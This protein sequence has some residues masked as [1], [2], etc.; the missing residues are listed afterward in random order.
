MIKRILPIALAGAALIG[1]I[2]CKNN[3]DMKHVNGID[4]KIIHDAPGK[5]AQIGDVVE[6]NIKVMADTMTIADSRKEAGK[7]VPMQV[8]AP[9]F[10][11][12]Y[13]AVFPMLS[14]GD[15]ALVEVSCDTLIKALQKQQAQLPPFIKRGKKI[16]FIISI[17]SVKSMDEFK[18]DMEAKKAGLV[19]Q[20]DKTLQDYFA[21]HNI[22]AQKTAS[23]L[24]YTIDKEGTGDQIVKGRSVTMNYTGKLLN[25]T[26]FDSNTEPVPGRPA[27]ANNKPFT[28]T[29]GS[30]QV[31]PGM[32][33]GIL[34]MKKGTKA[35]LYIPSGLAYGA[36]SPAP[37]IPANSI[38]MFN[39]DVT[40]VTNA[41]PPPPQVPNQ[42]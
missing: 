6:M 2:G 29:A 19:Q 8:Q 27:S 9:S 26:I 17:A 20:D 7:P 13:K 37:A 10:R 28:I 14:A 1:S 39:V 38:L 5:N 31:I 12:D 23:G 24:Y 42:Q 33:E 16:T 25:G 34:L 3:S 40:D 41:P 15:S 18:K 35:T 22:K 32:D 4:Y 30:M 21:Q 36:Q 11:G